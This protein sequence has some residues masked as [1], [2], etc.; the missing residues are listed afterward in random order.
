MYGQQYL[1]TVVQQR[2]EEALREAHTRR[3][4]K[5]VKGYYRPRSLGLRDIGSA[6]S[7]ALS[8]LRW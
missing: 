5:R 2:H 4:A 3:L 8:A 6:L 1:E 7:G